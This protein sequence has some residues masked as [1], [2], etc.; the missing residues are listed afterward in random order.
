MKKNKLISTIPSTS[1]YPKIGIKFETQMYKYKIV[2][3]FKISEL[4]MCNL[5]YAV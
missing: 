3:T 1:A 5:L 2:V 4:I